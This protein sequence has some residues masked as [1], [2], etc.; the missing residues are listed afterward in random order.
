MLFLK[1]SVF[2]FQIV[3]YCYIGKQLTLTYGKIVLWP[4]HSLGFLSQC[5]QVLLP[6]FPLVFPVHA[7]P[8][9]HI[10]KME[11]GLGTVCFRITW[12]VCLKVQGL[13][14][15]SV[16]WGLG[17]RICEYNSL[18]FLFHHYHH[19]GPYSHLNFIAA[20]LRVDI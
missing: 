17:C 15:E 16:T 4:T 11:L 13:Y 12:A 19:H 2:L 9:A 7:L 20:T 6:G 3:Y 14:H 1:S 18:L 5:Q 8:P 10:P